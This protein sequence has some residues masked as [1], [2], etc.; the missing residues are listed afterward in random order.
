MTLA[1]STL[2]GGCAA[3]VGGDSPSLAKRAIEGTW[4][5]PPAAPLPAAPGALPADLAGRLAQW[6]SQARTADAAFLAERPVAEQRVAAAVGAAVASEKWVSGQ[7]ALSRLIA[8]R[9][10]VTGA[11]ADIDRLYV[12][13]RV[14]EEIDG[15][16]AIHALRTRLVE[17][18][19]AEDV[20]LS[21][22][23][24]QLPSP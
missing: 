11:L 7:Q 24:S 13:R 6:E 21:R 22:L 5:V 23:Q 18:V 12:D 10:P 9:A 17:L 3:A 20:I 15:L 8:V 19:A 1:A 14:A 16:P 2:L 4:N